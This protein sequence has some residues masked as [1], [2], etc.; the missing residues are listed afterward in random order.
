MIDFLT[1]LVTGFDCGGADILR[2]IKF[3]WILLDI[4]LFVIPMILIIM[5]S[6]DLVKNVI[7][8]RADDAKK[9]LQIAI[10]RIIFC[11]ALFLI[12]TIVDVAVKLLG[13]VGVD[14]AKCIEIAQK[15]D[16]SKYEMD[17]DTFSP[18]K[19]TSGE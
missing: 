14:Y 1:F 13:D 12:P 16:L 10:K 4:V 15:D 9:N 7:S 3:V 19:D 11:M 5:V 18:K 17:Y 2:V 8:G 6:V